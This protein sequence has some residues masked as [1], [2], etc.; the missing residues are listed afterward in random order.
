MYMDG[1]EQQSNHIAPRTTPTMSHHVRTKNRLARIVRPQP[2]LVVP[3][4]SHRSRE[5]GAKG[6]KKGHDNATSKSKRNTTHI[7]RS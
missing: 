6:Q 5:G 1:N 7:H 2:G 3:R 4:C